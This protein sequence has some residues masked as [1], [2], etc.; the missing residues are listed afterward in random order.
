MSTNYSVGGDI[1]ST[2]YFDGLIEVEHSEYGLCTC[3]VEAV[4]SYYYDPGCMYLRNGDPGYPPEEE[5]TVT[6]VNIKEV[7]DENGDILEPEQ[8]MNNKEL[9]EAV[10]EALYEEGDWYG[11]DEEDI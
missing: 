5:L 2:V 1:M 7:T 11:D 10:D 3:S 8:Y 6:D 9:L 4:G